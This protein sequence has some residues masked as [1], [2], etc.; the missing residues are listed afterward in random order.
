MIR[1]CAFLLLPLVF[2]FSASSYAETKTNYSPPVKSLVLQTECAA[3]MDAAEAWCAKRVEK[4]IAFG[5]PIIGFQVSKIDSPEGK[6]R[7]GFNTECRGSF[8]DTDKIVQSSY[9]YKACYQK[10]ES[11]KRMVSDGAKNA[12]LESMITAPDPQP[13]SSAE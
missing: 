4:A 11:I 9:K 5:N 3:S 13:A 2:V 12:E 6:C 8:L 7:I 10:V 1:L